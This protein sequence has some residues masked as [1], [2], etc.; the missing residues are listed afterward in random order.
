MEKTADMLA[1]NVKGTVTL[2]NTEYRELVS[3]QTMLDMILG[4]CVKC[5]EKAGCPDK[6]IVTAVRKQRSYQLPAFYF[7]EKSGDGDA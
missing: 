4:S 2:T 3:C 6:N 5:A 7:L 1:I